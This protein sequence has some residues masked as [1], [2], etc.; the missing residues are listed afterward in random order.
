MNLVLKMPIQLLLCTTQNFSNI[1][2]LCLSCERLHFACEHALPHLC[3]YCSMFH[4][5]PNCDLLS[6]LCI[7]CLTSWLNVWVYSD[8]VLAFRNSLSSD[9]MINLISE[10]CL[11]VQFFRHLIKYDRMYICTC[12]MVSVCVCVCVC[13]CVWRCM[14]VCNPIA[15]RSPSPFP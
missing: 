2:C 5:V 9:L 13:V 15:Y 12:V 7:P 3:T 4:V 11:C 6:G 8:Q 1:C 14:C 10:H